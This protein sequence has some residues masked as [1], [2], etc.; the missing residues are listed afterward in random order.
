MKKWWEQAACLGAPSDVFFPE[1]D[2]YTRSRWDEARKFCEVCPVTQECVE[3]VM[4][5]EEASG[6][7]DGMWGGLTPKE[8]DVL[9]QNR[10]RGRRNP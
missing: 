8:R 5:I 2:D 10:I 3:F 7:R 6:R 1:V 4:P 9:W